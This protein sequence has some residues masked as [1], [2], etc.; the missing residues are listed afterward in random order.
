MSKNI[1]D[2][3]KGLDTKKSLFLYDDPELQYLKKPLGQA[4]YNSS[5]EESNEDDSTT[6]KDWSKKI[7]CWI[8]GKEYTGYNKHNHNKTQHHKFCLEMNKKWQKFCFD[9]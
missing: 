9:E 2:I 3:Q 1:R 7:K 8:C 5:K 4:H 6:K